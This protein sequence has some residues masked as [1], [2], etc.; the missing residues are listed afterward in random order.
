MEPLG[1]IIFAACMFTAAL[2]L[3]VEGTFLSI[4]LLLVPFDFFFFVFFCFFIFLH[5]YIFHF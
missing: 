1:V 5:F 2:Q 3:L 4:L